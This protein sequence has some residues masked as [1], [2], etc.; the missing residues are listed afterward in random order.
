MNSEAERKL[1]LGQH[2]QFPNPPND[3]TTM[4]W[5]GAA[6]FTKLKIAVALEAKPIAA[7]AL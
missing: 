7:S 6:T 2:E 4:L 1:Q 3:G 5:D